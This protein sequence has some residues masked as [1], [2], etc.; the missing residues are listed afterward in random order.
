MQN[1]INNETIFM[2]LLLLQRSLTFIYVQVQ[3]AVLVIIGLSAVISFNRLEH[4]V[5]V[6][7]V[8]SIPVEQ[9]SVTLVVVERVPVLWSEW[10]KYITKQ[11]ESV[12]PCI[13]ME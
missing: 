12:A 8:A 4:C 10:E 6:Q 1:I 9:F 3:T 5:L 7:L 2:L 13:E 11:R